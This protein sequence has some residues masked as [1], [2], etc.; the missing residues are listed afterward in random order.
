MKKRL[1]GLAPVRRRRRFALPGS[2]RLAASAVLFV[3]GMYAFVKLWTIPTEMD[4]HPALV[5]FAIAL[6]LLL[7]A[8]IVSA[9]HHRR[10]AR[11]DE[12][13]TLRL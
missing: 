12:N 2:M 1:K 3:I 6:V 4:L 11:E 13:S 5:V 8:A 9:V 7:I 10:R